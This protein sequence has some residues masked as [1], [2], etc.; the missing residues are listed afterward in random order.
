MT[1]T[2]EPTELDAAP[3]VVVPDLPP[4]GKPPHDDLTPALRLMVDELDDVY[5]GAD[6]PSID[7]TAERMREAT[8]NKSWDSRGQV[9]KAR[10]AYR[11]RHG[12]E[13]PP[14]KTRTA[15]ASTARTKPTTPRRTTVVRP[16]PQPAVQAPPV[17]VVR[18]EPP[19][20]VQPSPPETPTHPAEP[21]RNE[22]PVVRN[23]SAGLGWSRFGFG[24]GVVASTA[25]NIAHSFTPSPELVRRTNELAA[26]TGQTVDWNAWT[27]PVG[28]IIA[29]AFWPIALVVSVEVISR[30]MWPDGWRW[31]AMRFGG[32]SLVAAVA[33]FISY[34]HLHGLI[35]SYGE[36]AWSA[37]VGPLAIDG[38]MLVCSAAL[39]AIGQHKRASRKED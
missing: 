32:V 29:A 24:L 9:D 38:L 10:A 16:D 13:T 30:V 17:A 37:A 21:K 4:A 2:M 5:G 7:K 11:A 8:G 26:A 28:T 3:P 35:S 18:D 6:C 34:K 1:T 12:I 36:D 33:A 27:P 15:P 22:Q 39:L 14:K 20:V 25:A 19:P 31:K 23:S